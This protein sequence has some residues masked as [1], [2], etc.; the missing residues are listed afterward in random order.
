MK[1]L[2][3]GEDFALAR[4]EFF[5]FSR[6]IRYRP[7][8]E[9]SILE[10]LEAFSLKLFSVAILYDKCLR[11]LADLESA[12]RD[13]MAQ[14]DTVAMP[15]TTNCLMETSTYFGSFHYFFYSLFEALAHIT[16]YLY[17]D[18]TRGAIPSRDFASQVRYFTE[19]EPG[20]NS[21]YTKLLEQSKPWIDPIL[22][23]RHAFTHFF[24]PFLGFDEAF[25]VIFEHRQPAVDS[26][27]RKKTFEPLRTYTV[28]SFSNLLAF[29]TD[30][31]R[32]HRSRVPESKETQFLREGFRRSSHPT[33][34]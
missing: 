13:E 17:Q 10:Y 26:I 16:R 25:S 1:T 6:D 32:V 11:S 29:L 8:Q 20:R 3:I 4:N 7:K 14:V 27:D 18:E 9:P 30:Y 22:T 2:T 23:N 24:T 19:I 5:L 15:L 21:E 12:V 28:K 31:V 34:S 33:G